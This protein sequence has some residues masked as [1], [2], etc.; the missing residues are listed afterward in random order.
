MFSL[1][2]LTEQLGPNFKLDLSCEDEKVFENREIRCFASEKSNST[3]FSVMTN[4]TVKLNS[5][6]EGQI[7]S[8]D[9]TQAKVKSIVFDK[10]EEGFKQ[11]KQFLFFVCFHF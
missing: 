3:N 5:S 7:T 4:E 6:I 1:A 2:Y 9:G 10:N 8:Q 11:V